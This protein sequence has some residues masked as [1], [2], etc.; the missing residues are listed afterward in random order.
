MLGR[1]FDTVGRKPMIAG[2]YILSGVLLIIT[3]FLFKADVLDGATTQTAAWCV[4]F[5]FARPARARPT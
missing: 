1:L 5:F 3:A 2:T 4:I